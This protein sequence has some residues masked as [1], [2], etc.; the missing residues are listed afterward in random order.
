MAKAGTGSRYS[1]FVDGRFFEVQDLARL[2]LGRVAHERLRRD[3]AFYYYF[4]VPQ[5]SPRLSEAPMRCPPLKPPP[6]TSAEKHL[7]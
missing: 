2:G 6:A 4:Q 3:D 1:F 5:D 7:P